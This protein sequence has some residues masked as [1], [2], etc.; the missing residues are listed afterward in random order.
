MPAAAIGGMIALYQ[1]DQSANA[2]SDSLSE[3]RRQADRAYGMTQQQL[4]LEQKRYDEEKA[5]YAPFRK[6]LKQEALSNEPMGYEQDAKAISDQYGELRRRAGASGFGS[7]PIGL[8]RSQMFGLDVSEANARGQAYGRARDRRRNIRQQLGMQGNQLGATMPLPNNSASVAQVNQMGNYYGN[9]AGLYG[10]QAQQAQAQVGQAA[11]AAGQWL[12]QQ[13]FFGNNGPVKIP[14]TYGMNTYGGQPTY[15]AP[16][17]GGN[18][19]GG[20]DYYG[21]R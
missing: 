18:S 15:G 6:M 3:Q 21:G 4:A 13:N 12:G 1:A 9:M 5:Y 16:T 8:R 20:L 17:F 10:Q 11:N 2:A 19:Y 7:G 14:D